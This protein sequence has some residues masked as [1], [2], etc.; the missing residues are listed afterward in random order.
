MTS[1]SRMRLV[2]FALGCLFLYSFF[3]LFE[4]VRAGSIFSSLFSSFIEKGA[5]GV[6]DCVG[7]SLS[8]S[9]YFCCLRE[10]AR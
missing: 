9:F 6:G 2:S 8:H 7:A 3:F 5:S 1:S 4:V 10:E